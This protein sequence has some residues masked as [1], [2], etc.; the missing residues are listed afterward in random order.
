M[1]WLVAPT[2]AT[3]DTD[4][5]TWSPAVAVITVWPVGIAVIRVGWVGI[6]I[7]RVPVP[8][9]IITAAIGSTILSPTIGNRFSGRIGLREGC[10][11]SGIGYCRRIRFPDAAAG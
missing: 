3:S 11:G 1:C 4:A 6:A 5:D 10:Q 2:P 9:A 8:I 7:I